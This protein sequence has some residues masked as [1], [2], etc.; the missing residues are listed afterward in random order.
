MRLLLCN[1]SPQ[2]APIIHPLKTLNIC[3]ISKFPLKVPSITQALTATLISVTLSLGIF[4]TYPPHVFSI[5]F[6]IPTEESICREEEN[7]ADPKFTGDT[8]KN[9]GIVEEAWQIVNDSF[10]DTGRHRWSPDSWLVC[11]APLQDFLFTVHF[12]F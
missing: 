2:L 6:S 9:E 11:I 7:Y 8:V 1:S 10:L 5:D 4:Y 12:Q 3:P